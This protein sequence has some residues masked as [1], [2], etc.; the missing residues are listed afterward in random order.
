MKNYIYILLLTFSILPLSIKAQEVVQ[1]EPLFEYPVAPE[2]L[3]SLSD[4][5]DYIVKNFWNNF[6][7]KSKQPLDQH[8][9]NQAFLVYTSAMP[10]ATIK[11]VDESVNKLL[12]KISGNPVFLIQF[13]KAAEE[14]MYGPRA[15]M[16]IDDVYL[17]FLDAILKNKKISDSRKNKYKEQAE[18]LRESKV[19]MRAPSFDFVNLDGEVKKYIPMSTPTI[20]IF[21]NPDNTDWRLARLR[22]DS[23][24]KLVEALEKGKVNILYIVPVDIKNW[25]ENVNNYNSRWNVGQSNDAIKHYDI[26]IDPTIYLIGPDGNII[27]KNMNLEVAVNS[28]LDLIN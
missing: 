8:A 16:W 28:V 4:K 21:G 14:T 1:I 18:Q 6:D 17:K 20:L 2:E 11:E 15:E 26:R 5:C 27:N 12:N 10:Y 9:L 7:F 24:F 19:G 25:K 23:N 13:T 3:V 22:M